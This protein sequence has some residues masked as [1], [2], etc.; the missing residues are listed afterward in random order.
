[1]K[2]FL[3]FLA[4]Y[5][6]SQFYRAFLAVI[7]PELANELALDRQTLSNLQALWIL[8][9]VVMQ[10]PVG[11]ALDTIGPRRVVSGLMA[12]AVAGAL[13]FAR[14]HTALEIDAAMLLIGVG[15]SAVYMGGV[16]ALGRVASPA[17]F[18]FLTSALLGLGSAGNLLAASPMGY[19]TAEIGWRAAMVWVAALTAASAVSVWVG[20]ED[21]PRLAH[22]QRD[23]FIGGIREILSLRPLWPLLPL[24]G[25]SYAILL[26]ERG[27]WAG[28]FLSEVYG[29]AAIERGHAL[30]AMALAM[31]IGALVYGQLDRTLGRRKLIVATGSALTA[32]GFLALGLA[33]PS[34]A[35]AIALLSAIG[36]CGLTYGVLMAHG[37]AFFPERL[38]GRG[39]TTMNV[40]FIGGAGL[41]QPISG[42][43]MLAMR[44]APPALAFQRLH[45]A[46]GLILA[47]AL[48]IYLFTREVDP[49]RPPI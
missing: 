21:P 22:T 26:A 7:A 37:R 30:L 29:L 15:C 39:I 47:A 13:L 18:G 33:S 23:S 28:P 27:L 43:W 24:T 41:L 31:S 49:V 5:V 46:F 34:L 42:A 8:G 40:F 9:F 11:W 45:L 25:V 2:P 44:D 48:A 36:F 19:A 16:Y 4:A 32:A 1:M 10:F 14:A 38:L 20:I 35:A 17:R 3:I 6:L 12:V